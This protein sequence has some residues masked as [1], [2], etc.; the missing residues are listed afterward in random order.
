[1]SPRLSPRRPASLTGSATR[2][3]YYYQ[4]A[5]LV[6]E[7]H[8]QELDPGFRADTGFI[9]RV[10]YDEDWFKANRT[11]QG[12]DGTIWNQLQAGMFWDDAHDSGGRLLGRSAEPFF[13]FSGPR[14]SFVQVRAGPRQEYWDGKIFDLEELLLFSQIRPRT[15]LNMVLQARIG[16]AVD[17]SNS[18]V[19]RERRVQPQI[20]WNATRH[21]LVRL[22]HTSD[23]LTRSGA[24][25]FD[26][27][28][29]DLRVTWQFNLRSFVRVTLQ[30]QDI[31]RNVALYA[32]TDD[33]AALAIARD[34]AALRVQ[35]ESADAALRGLLRQSAR[36]PRIGPTRANRPHTV[37]E[38]ELRVDAVA[39]RRG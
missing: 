19:G 29:T 22:Q 37:P 36:G 39:G 2:L 7:L 3:E 5:R 12:H 25:V 11:W 13:S 1:M 15:G 32:L 16:Q 17:Y 33:R 31:D 18:A 34:A 20:D 6:R 21:L 10:D 14:Q 23:V 26:A 38:A 27:E 24:Q 30:R 35:A 9:P 8:H 4:Y 28:L